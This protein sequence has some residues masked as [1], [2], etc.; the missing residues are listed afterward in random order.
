MRRVYIGI[1]LG[2]KTCAAAAIDAR[3][4][5]LAAEQF[6]TTERNLIAFVKAQKGKAGVLIE[7]CELA[8]WVMRTFLP[9]P[10]S[11]EVSDPKHNAWISKGSWKSDPVDALKLAKL[12][13]LG[14]YSPHL[15]PRGRGHGRLQ[16]RR[17]AL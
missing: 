15:P 5:L 10:E 16:G 6:K 11:V 13:R 17:Q 3:E 9:H 12:L 1:D 2:S 8:G 14:S 4:G 7:E